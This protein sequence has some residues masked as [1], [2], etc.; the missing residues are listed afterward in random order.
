MIMKCTFKSNLSAPFQ[1]RLNC[2]QVL[3][4]ASPLALWAGGQSWPKRWRATAVQDAIAPAPAPFIAQALLLALLPFAILLAGCGA[5]HEKENAATLPTARVR[6]Q[7]VENKSRMVANDEVGT[8]RAKLHA[9]LEARLSGRI[10]ELPVTLGETVQQGQLIARLD[11]AEVAARLAQAQASLEEADRDWKRTSALFA[12]QSATRAEYDSAQSRQQI[13]QSAVAEA[14]AMMSYVEIRAPFAGVVTKKWADVGD[15]AAPGKPLV[16]LE[17]PSAL[18]LWADVPDALG[19]NVKSGDRLAVRIGTATNEV[20]GTV[21]E[22][23]PAADPDS[24]TFLMKL[25]LPSA[26]GLR[27]GQFGRV[28]V[29]VGEA[30][31]I[32]VPLT[33]VIQRG[34]M[35]LVF[36]VAN[37]RA[38]LRL[39]KTGDR[40]GDE[41]EVVSGLNSGEQVVTE[42]ATDLVDGQP[43]SIQNAK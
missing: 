42:G 6:V 35:E 5:K 40:V 33:S 10:A 26:P 16:N 37:G 13:A 19:G 27:S 34:Q 4:C 41:V 8:V 20:E 22:V 2:R 11:A 38:E 25:D 17:D 21:A 7:T 43:V 15:L 23:S 12:Q 24:R 32:R 14:Q 28:A 9:T 3:E 39:V 36:V 29:P 1:H 31:A 18:Q 30:N